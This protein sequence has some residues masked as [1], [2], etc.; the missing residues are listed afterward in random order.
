[1]SFH[2]HT[3]VRNVQR[4]KDLSTP[5]VGFNQNNEIISVARLNYRQGGSAV[6]KGNGWA[7]RRGGVVWN[8]EYAGV[9]SVQ[10]TM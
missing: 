3:H 6:W 4:Q 8:G 2:I 5:R 9:Q 7:V 1:M 10:Y